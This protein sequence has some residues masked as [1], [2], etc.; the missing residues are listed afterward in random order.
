MSLPEELEYAIVTPARDEAEN[1]ERLGTSLAAQRRLP[2]RWVIV[3][4]G[5]TDGT[6]SVAESLAA[7]YSWVTVTTDASTEALV[8]GGPVVRAFHRGVA[9]L[10]DAGS[11]P[12]VIVKVDADTSFPSDYYGRLLAAF[13]GDDR[14]GIASGSAWEL[15]NGVW[16]QHHMTGDQ[17]WGAARAYRRACLE[18][19]LPLEERMGWDGIDVYKAGLAGWNTKTLTDLPF[20]HHRR[21][22]ERDGARRLAW[23]AQ[24]R[25]SHFMGYRFW[26][27]AARAAHHARKD[28]VAF[29]MIG[30]YLSAA[31]RRERRCADPDV[32]EAI[33]QQQSLRSLPRRVREAAGR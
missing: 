11:L 16:A 1:L 25:A 26:Y 32:R 3:D 19:V 27:L 10:S 15:E 28:P 22:G 31:L 24:G 33:R 4:N 7:K 18:V 23:A 5:S 20:R 21:E 29:A 9:I 13:A 12:D 14:L 30:G 8:R 17:V 2:A 6:H